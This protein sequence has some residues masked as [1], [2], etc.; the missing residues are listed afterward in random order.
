MEKIMYKEKLKSPINPIAALI[1]W[2]VFLC[3]FKLLWG[4]VPILLNFDGS[5]IIGQVI[6]YILTIVFGWV[7]Y[8]KIM[9]EYE[10]TLT[11]TKL[12]FEKHIS[13]KHAVIRQ[14]ALENIKDIYISDNVKVKNCQNFIRPFQ[15]ETIVTITFNDGDHI[16]A[17]K[18]KPSDKLS[19]KLNKLQNA[20]AEELK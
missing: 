19:D 4:I 17:V 10:V 14:I 7:L 1:A 13:K 9:T 6:S 3:L 16:S 2:I 8:S 12:I 11:D 18:F 20:A 15:K 5:V